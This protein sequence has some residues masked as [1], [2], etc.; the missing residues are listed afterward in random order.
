MNDYEQKQISEMMFH[1]HLDQAASHMQAMSNTLPMT[2]DVKQDFN[3]V[4]KSMNRIWRKQD[5]HIEEMRES[6]ADMA[7]LI[8]DFL[9]LFVKSKDHEK[10]IDIIR[11]HNEDAIAAENSIT[12]HR[13]IANH[14]QRHLH[15]PNQ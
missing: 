3:I 6:F 15:V 7:S 11:K 1:Y 2:H 5:S 9:Q 8:G 4:I 10:L 12:I 13:T 14:Q